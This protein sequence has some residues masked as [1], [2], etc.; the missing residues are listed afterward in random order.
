MIT[1]IVFRGKLGIN[2]LVG[3]ALALWWLSVPWGKGELPPNLLV[4]F[5]V[6]NLY[7]VIQKAQFPAR[8]SFQSGVFTLKWWLLYKVIRHKESK[9]RESMRGNKMEAVL[10]SHHFTVFFGSQSWHIWG[11][12]YTRNLITVDLTIGSIIET[13]SLTLMTKWHAKVCDKRWLSVVGELICIG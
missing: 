9:T 5:L 13:D 6:L 7:S 8:C 12:C 4:L 1:F 11:G 3:L 10:S 2:C